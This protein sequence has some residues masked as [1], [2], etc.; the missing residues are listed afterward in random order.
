MLDENPFLERGDEQADREAFGLEQQDAPVPAGDR[1]AEQA[2]QTDAATEGPASDDGSD[3]E[4]QTDGSSP[5]E[6]SWDGGGSVEMAPDDAEWG[7]DA[8]PAGRVTMMTPAVPRI[9]PAHP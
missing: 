8:P 9:W 4:A 6:E 3:I 1:I 2:V 5:L 7:G